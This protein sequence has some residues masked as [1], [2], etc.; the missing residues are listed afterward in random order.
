MTT[1]PPR[2]EKLN[3]LIN[4]SGFA[5]QLAV[6]AAV[7]AN[8]GRLGWR[9]VTREHPWTTS[10]ATGFT[11]LVLTCG[12]LYLVVECKR[13]RDAVW[14]FLMPE[15]DQLSRTHARIAWIDTVPHHKPLAGWDDIQVYPESAEADFCAIRGQGEK[16]RPL[17]ERIASQVVEASDGLCADLITLHERSARTKLVIPVIVTN[18]E[19]VVGEFDPAK[20]DLSRGEVESAKFTTVEHLRFRKS[21]GP[22][23]RPEDYD[24]EEVAD[25]GAEAV[26]TVFVVSAGAFVKWMGAVH[27]NGPDSSSPWVTARGRANAMGV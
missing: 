20:I 23:S 16:D 14:L 11:D 26:R 24:P 25:L 13:T 5:F 27:I 12:N 1:P 3:D 7:R 2:E 9:V 10:Q 22:S 6:E 17:L 4:A 19:L 8:P 21:L 15:K 18:A